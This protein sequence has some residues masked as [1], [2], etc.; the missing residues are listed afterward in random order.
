MNNKEE[1]TAAHDEHDLVVRTSDDNRYIEDSGFSVA[2]NCRDLVVFG[3]V[4][5]DDEKLL[6]HYIPVF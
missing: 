6:T 1:I 4:L 3:V 2:C 5:Y